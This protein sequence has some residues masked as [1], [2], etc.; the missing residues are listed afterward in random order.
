[1]YT[2][3][4]PSEQTKIIMRGRWG[5]RKVVNSPVINKLC[6]GVNSDEAGNPEIREAIRDPII[7]ED[8]PIGS[9]GPNG[10]HLIETT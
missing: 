2:I 7:T 8:M 10:F 3:S 6:D 9:A 1:M 5:K 4:P